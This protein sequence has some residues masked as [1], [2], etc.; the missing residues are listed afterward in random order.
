[1]WRS[2]F[3]FIAEA[4][5][6]RIACCAVDGML[7]C[8]SVVSRIVHRYGESLINLE[9]DAGI[10]LRGDLEISGIKRVI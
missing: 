2:E 9:A 4:L 5:T 7:K 6:S 3:C 8:V 1:M 10:G